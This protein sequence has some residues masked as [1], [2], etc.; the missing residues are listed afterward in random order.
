MEEYS[1]ETLL[2]Y[3]GIAF[4][5]IIIS[6]ALIKLKKY[7]LRVHRIKHNKTEVEFESTNNLK[8]NDLSPYS[9]PILFYDQINISQSAELDCKSIGLTPKE[10]IDFILKEAT[11][12][13]KMFISEFVSLPIT[14]GKNVLL[15][16]WDKSTATIER[17]LSREKA[18]PL[19][20][21]WSKCLYLYRKASLLPYR[22]QDTEKLSY[23]TEARRSFNIFKDLI[24]NVKTF[25]FELKKIDKEFTYNFLDL[26]SLI[27]EAEFGLNNDDFA[28]TISRFEAILSTAHKLIL[29]YAPAGNINIKSQ[30]TIF[31][32]IEKP[33]KGAISVLIVDDDKVICNMLEEILERSEFN[34][35]ITKFHNANKAF[36]AMVEHDFDVIITD[37]SM[38]KIDGREVAVAAKKSNKS[39]KIIVMSG[40]VGIAEM[41]ELGT[42]IFP[43]D[44]FIAIPFKHEELIMIFKKL[45][46]K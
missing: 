31:K 6:F 1:L 26:D 15:L 29:Q 2:P 40:Y 27:S 43:C 36:K 45:I 11:H 10:I 8:K 13:P 30:Y 19:N 21:I 46:N 3:L 4:I 22:L 34:F 41:A 5:I 20:D 7:G 44:Y 28:T 25:L 17:I 37:I 35:H 12:H 23:S 38:P 14:Y 42:N 9:K 18:Y 33:V 32:K 24:A 16:S 39:S